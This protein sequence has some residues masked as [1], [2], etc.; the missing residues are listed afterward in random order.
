[1]FP[2]LY[3][4]LKLNVPTSTEVSEGLLTSQNVKGP[5]SLRAAGLESLLDATTV[6]NTRAQELK[7]ASHT[8]HL[9]H[10]FTFPRSFAASH[11]K[12]SG[13]FASLATDNWFTALDSLIRRKLLTIHGDF[14]IIKHYQLWVLPH[15]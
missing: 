3:V 14:F 12:P 1:M 6:C 11:P 10:T 7:A 8:P 5:C 4:Y 13:I 15:K 9:I 2:F